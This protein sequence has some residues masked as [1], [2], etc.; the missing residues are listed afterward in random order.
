MLSFESTDLDGLYVATRFPLDNKL[1][2]LT[3]FYCQDE[4]KKIGIYDSIVQINQTLTNKKGS[5]RGMHFQFYPFTEDKIVSCTKGMIFDVAVDIR[6]DSPTFLQHYAQILSK[7]NHKSMCIP[8]GFAHGFQSMSSSCEVLYFHTQFYS[9]E[10]EH[11]LRW[12]DQSISIDWPLPVSN[13]SKR[14]QRH[15]LIDQSFN[16]IQL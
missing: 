9:A 11:G 8:K 1:G 7:D 13:I 14:D 2:D 16:G 4:F 6:K 12:N 15:D 10:F 3:R 5:I